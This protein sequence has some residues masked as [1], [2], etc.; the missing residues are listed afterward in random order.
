[1]SDKGQKNLYWLPRIAG[2][3]CSLFCFIQKNYIPTL[4]SKKEE[5]LKKPIQNKA[6]RINIYFLEDL[7]K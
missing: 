1:M 2:I 7:I 6:F 3:I 4:F 5:E